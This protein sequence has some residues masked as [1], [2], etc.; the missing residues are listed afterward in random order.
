MMAEKLMPVASMPSS[1]PAT[2]MMTV[3]SVTITW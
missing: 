1:T 2:D 3:E